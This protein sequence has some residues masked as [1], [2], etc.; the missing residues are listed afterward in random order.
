M[1]NSY[2]IKNSTDEKIDPSTEELQRELIVE[3][4]RNSNRS[5]SDIKFQALALAADLVGTPEKEHG[6]NS[7]KLWTALSDCYIGDEDGQPVLLKADIWLEIP[8]NTVTNL[9]FVS[10]TGGTVY[11][12]SAN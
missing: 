9:R 2:L 10:A 3:F 12:I 8:I 6:C 5:T 11:V 1:Q 7:I 4:G